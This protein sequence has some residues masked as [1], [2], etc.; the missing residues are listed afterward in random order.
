MLRIA[1]SELL[2][3]VGLAIV[4]ALHDSLSLCSVLDLLVLPSAHGL[5][6]LLRSRL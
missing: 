1:L 3:F 5:L 2:L 6:T 4:V